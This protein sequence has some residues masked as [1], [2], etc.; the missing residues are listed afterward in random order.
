MYRTSASTVRT[1]SSLIKVEMNNEKDDVEIYVRNARDCRV[2]AE[3]VINLLPEDFL[4]LVY[5]I[6]QAKGYVLV[7]PLEGF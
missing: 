2:E 4:D 6:L 5:P 3:A 7:A 1:D